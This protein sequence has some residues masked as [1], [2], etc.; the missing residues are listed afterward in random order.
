MRMN[1]EMP[2]QITSEEL[3]KFAPEM[4]P[5]VQRWGKD[6]FQFAG[7]VAGT[8]SAI[9]Y[10]LASAERFVKLRTPTLVI[11]NNFSSLIDEVIRARGWEMPD[12]LECIGDIG[13]AEQLAQMSNRKIVIH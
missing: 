2:S 5:V 3:E 13:R 4:R 11:M 12:F 7:Q 9:D 6:M 1:G 10:M 8:N